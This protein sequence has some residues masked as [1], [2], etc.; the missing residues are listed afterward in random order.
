[1]TGRP[2]R[3][4]QLVRPV[5]EATKAI[6]GELR[7]LGWWTEGAVPPERLAGHGPMG[8]DSLS[9]AEWLQFVMLPRALEAASGLGSFPRSS[10]VARWAS[11]ELDGAPADTG[12]LV[13]MLGS[14]DA[15]FTVSPALCAAAW[16][17]DASRFLADPEVVSG[18]SMFGLPNRLDAASWE[19]VSGELAALLRD[20]APVDS[21]APDTGR[22]AL[23]AA[24]AFGCDPLEQL[25]LGHGA[26]ATLCDTTGRCA[27]DWRLLRLMTRLSGALD[28][29]RGVVSARLCQLWFP[30]SGRLSTPL[31]AL[32]LD[33]PLA[34]DAFSRLP[35]SDPC[36]MMSLGD[37]AVS[38]LSASE[39]PFWTRSPR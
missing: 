14:F 37:D 16:A 4:A 38:R 18:P 5:L 19:E 17:P 36:A 32:E 9:T 7:R 29:A 12:P 23:M 1:M 10:E 25:L 34:P 22:T 28:A 31:V 13:A 11:R 8:T 26:D 39:A 3:D 21:R 24:I 35:S 6:E 2:V 30:V 15:L 20:G 33:G 27:A